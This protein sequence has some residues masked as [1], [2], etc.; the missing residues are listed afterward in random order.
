MSTYYMGA[1]HDCRQWL[2]LSNVD[3]DYATKSLHHWATHHGHI[4]HQIEAA[5][6]YDPIFQYKIEGLTPITYIGYDEWKTE[7]NGEPYERVWYGE[8]DF[9]YNWDASEQ[10]AHREQVQE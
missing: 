9:G 8:D 5:T 7:R 1:C 6:E 4:G 2:W 10:E 3:V